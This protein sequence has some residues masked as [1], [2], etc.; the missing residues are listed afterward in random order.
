MSVN[1]AQLF[2]RH[3]D[4]E[5]VA[6]FVGEYLKFFIQQ[7]KSPGL[8]D[9]RLVDKDGNRGVLILPP[10]R[11]WITILEYD[12]RNSDLSLGASI[13]KEFNC[14]VVGLEVQGCV[15]N[16]RWA[17]L[18]NGEHRQGEILLKDE[19][20]RSEVL[21]DFKDAE[22]LAWEKGIQLGLPPETLFVRQQDFGQSQNSAVS[23]AS[24][25]KISREGNNLRFQG[26]K[27]SVQMPLEPTQPRVYLDMVMHNQAQEKK[28]CIESRFLWGNPEPA[29][30][31]RFCALLRRIQRRYSR[32][33]G[34]AL[35]DI[36]FKVMAGHGKKEWFRLPED[37]ALFNEPEPGVEPQSTH[38][39]AIPPSPQSPM[40]TKPEPKKNPF[41]F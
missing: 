37:L 15:F 20:E 9:G 38:A 34:L 2:V 36:G 40:Q 4:H 8:P 25:Y 29:A 18:E 5:A 6:T 12:H 35:K 24:E 41:A 31:E 27:T 32:A 23:N 19:D 7:Y 21:P 13:S 28:F 22:L 11:G 16:Y 14:R 26:W 10:V 39:P 17:L 30:M 33:T 3:R 1:T